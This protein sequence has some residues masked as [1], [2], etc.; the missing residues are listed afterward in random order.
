MIIDK[1]IAF[2]ADYGYN[3]E[4]ID[5]KTRIPLQHE[6]ALHSIRGRSAPTVF[7][8]LWFDIGQQTM[9][10]FKRAST[11]SCSGYS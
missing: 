2:L 4:A 9:P 7:L 3:L 6:N 11:I 1:E 10:V 8:A 5:Q